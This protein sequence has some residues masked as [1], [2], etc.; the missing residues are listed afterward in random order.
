MSLQKPVDVCACLGGAAEI[1]DR[2]RAFR[3]TL[4][5]QHAVRVQAR[6]EIE[7]HQGTGRLSPLYVAASTKLAVQS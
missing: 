3:L 5:G 6:V 4:F 1:G 7:R 2:Q